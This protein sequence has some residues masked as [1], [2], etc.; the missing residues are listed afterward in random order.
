MLQ[1]HAAA[2]RAHHR[3]AFLAGVAPGAF[4][5]AQARSYTNLSRLPLTTFRYR[6]GPAVRDRDAQ[7]AVRRKY[8]TSAVIVHVVLSYALRRADRRAAAHDLWWT[9]VR[10]G[11]RIVVAGDSDLSSYGATTWR[12]PWDFGPLTVT[13]GRHSLVLGHPSQGGL[14]RQVA[15][16]VDQAVPA[17][18]AVVGTSWPRY[19]AVVLPATPAELQTDLA[20]AAHTGARVAAAAV[21]DGRDPLSG[22][23]QGERL[24]LEPE[25]YRQLSAVGQRITLRHELTHVATTGETSDTTPTWLVEGLAEYVGNLHSGQPV[26]VAAGE[27]TA[28]VRRHGPRNSCRAPRTSPAPGRQWRTRR[29]GWPAGSSQPASGP[30]GC[31]ASTARSARR[32][33]RRMRRCPPRCTATFTCRPPRFVARWRTYVAGRLT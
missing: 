29:P 25:Q 22:I 7:R 30:P 9:V 14:P 4:R 11:G 12:G 18:S 2:V 21:N 16:A 3:Q 26:P 23:V 17:V 15:T 33:R 5:R 32:A 19:V 13:H 20:S 28:Q 1:E 27:L 31:C 8:D 24:V 10:R 6:L